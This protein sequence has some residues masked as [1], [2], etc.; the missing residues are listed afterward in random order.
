MDSIDRSDSNVPARFPAD[1]PRTPAPI[2]AIPR[3]LA[4]TPT[5]TP[6]QVNPQVIL[7]G[8][9]RHWWRI[10]LL[11]LVVSAPLAYLIYALVEPTYEAFSVLRIEPAQPELFSPGGLGRGID[12]LKS[13]QPYL[14]TQVEIIKSDPLLEKAI[15]KPA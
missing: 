13:V 1:S 8:I 14:Q 7:R 9:S 15:T 6:L 11:W 3:D 2:A 10:L 5:T 12:D 4:L